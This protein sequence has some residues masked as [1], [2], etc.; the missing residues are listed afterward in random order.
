[1]YIGLNRPAAVSQLLSLQFIVLYNSFLT[2][3]LALLIIV[4]ILLIVLA[5]I[6]QFVKMHV[7]RGF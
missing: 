5:K 1:M 7:Y 6:I 4:V 3:L 2:L